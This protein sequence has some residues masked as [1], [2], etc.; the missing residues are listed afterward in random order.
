LW[1]M[2][3]RNLVFSAIYSD[4]GTAIAPC[5]QN[6]ALVVILCVRIDKSAC[7]R[8][9]RNAPK[10]PSFS[11]FVWTPRTKKYPSCED[12]KGSHVYLRLPGGVYGQSALT[13]GKTERVRARNCSGE[14][15][16][17]RNRSATI[18]GSLTSCCW[19]IWTAMWYGRH[20]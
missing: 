15:G 1:S 2:H 8:E 7:F 16:H 18:D 10:L 4:D 6:L 14:T 3:A 13:T 11:L 12:N 19:D 17:G 9:I 20:E 5:C